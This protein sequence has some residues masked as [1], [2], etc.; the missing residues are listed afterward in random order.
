MKGSVSE[1]EEGK[2]EGIEKRSEGRKGKKKRR[3]KEGRRK[4][5]GREGREERGQ[6][7]SRLYSSHI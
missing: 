7:I 3:G 2:E 4:E 6:C 5:G 1:R